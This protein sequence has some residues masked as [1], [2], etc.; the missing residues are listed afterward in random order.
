MRRVAFYLLRAAAAVALDDNE[1]FVD[2]GSVYFD[3]GSIIVQRSTFE[4]SSAGDDGGALFLKPGGA[5]VTI[6]NSTFLDNEAN[7]NG[8]CLFV[9]NYA[10]QIFRNEFISCSAADLGITSSTARFVAAK[11]W[12]ATRWISTA[13][14]AR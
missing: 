2:G 12:P 8:G 1:A 7:D 5:Q 10:G 3:S 4:G 14:T 9:D 13:L 11:Y 6:N